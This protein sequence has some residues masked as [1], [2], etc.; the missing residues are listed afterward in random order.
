MTDRKLSLGIDT[1]N[2]TTSVALADQ[3]GHLLYTGGQLLKVKAG[4]RGLRQSEALYQHIVNLPELIEDIPSTFN[5]KENLG[6]ICYSDRPRPL[7]D[8][9]MPVFRAGMGH[10]RSLSRMM[11]VPQMAVSHQEN[12]IRA[13]IYGAGLIPSELDF[14]ILATHF[15]GGTSEVLFVTERK[16]GYNCEIVSETLDLNAGQ[17]ID[18]IGVKIGFQ[19][20]AGKEMEKLAGE[21]VKHDCA[22]PSTIDGMNFHFSGQENKALQLLEQGAPREEIAYGVLRAVA[23]TLSKVIRQCCGHYR[24]K[25]VLF[26]GGVMSNQLIRGIIEKELSRKQIRLHFTKACFATDNAVGCAMIGADYLSEQQ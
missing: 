2:Y 20:P 6:I 17:L 5:L 18:R 24:I 22:I 4:E 23:K 16:G 3:E 15:S 26:S 13:A 8:S 1:S 19:F 25:D 7:E 11:E 12:H 21:A 10:A 9:Y 14:P